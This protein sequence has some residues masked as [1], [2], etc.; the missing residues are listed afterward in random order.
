MRIESTHAERKEVCQVNES[1]RDLLKS[2]EAAELLRVPVRTL[3]EW[4]MRG[5]GPAA[6]RVGKR[7]L[8]DRKDVERWLEAHREEPVSAA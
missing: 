7:V 5:V 6:Y 3:Y 2:F 4:R 8:Y 1:P